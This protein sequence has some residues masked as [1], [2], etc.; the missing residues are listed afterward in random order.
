MIYFLNLNQPFGFPQAKAWGLLRV[1]TERRFHLRPEGPSLAPS[2][3]QWP[4]AKRHLGPFPLEK[5]KV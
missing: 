5:G 3:Y 4:L 1:D 2:K